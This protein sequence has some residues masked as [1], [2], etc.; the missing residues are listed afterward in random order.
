MIP[1]INHTK[2]HATAVNFEM[3]YLIVTAYFQIITTRSQ[4]ELDTVGFILSH[5]KHAHVS[6][7]RP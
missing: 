4:A 5:L 2:T 3:S 1:E 6:Q 7:L